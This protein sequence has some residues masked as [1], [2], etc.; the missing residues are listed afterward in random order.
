MNDP[1]SHPAHYTAF[2]AEVIDITRQLSFNRG[3]V[4]K[5]AARAGLK[6]SETLLQDLKKAKFYLED[7]IALEE[8]RAAA[9]ESAAAVDRMLGG[10]T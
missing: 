10:L 4:V 1:V 6:D 8:K 7:E 3:N 2:D 5:Y 9:R